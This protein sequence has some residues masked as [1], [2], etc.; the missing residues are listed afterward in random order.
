MDIYVPAKL[1]VA[2]R[3][4]SWQAEDT[5]TDD[6]VLVSMANDLGAKYESS[7]GEST[8]VTDY[9]KMGVL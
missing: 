3:D 4:A 1:T 8:T 6:P 5:G 9:Q 7:E 2:Y